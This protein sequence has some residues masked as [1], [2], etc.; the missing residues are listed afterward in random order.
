MIIKSKDDLGHLV[1]VLRD[2]RIRQGLTI[3]TA[4]ALSACGR[5]TLSRLEN[6]KLSRES[7]MIIFDYAEALGVELEITPHRKE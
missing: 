5:E 2:E 7:M 1:A 6:G 3:G 4:A